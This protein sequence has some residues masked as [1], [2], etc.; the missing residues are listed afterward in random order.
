M[1]P[2]W[3]CCGIPTSS[4]NDFGRLVRRLNQWRKGEVI[5]EDSADEVDPR[6]C[7]SCGLMLEFVG[8][9]CPRCINRSAAM[10]RVLELLRPYWLRAS[11]MMAMLL[12]GIGL[13]MIGPRLTQF[14]VDHVLK[15]DGNAGPNPF[16]M[17]EGWNKLNLLM[18]VV[19]TLAAVQIGRALINVFNGRLGSR[20]GTSI[21]YDIRGRLVNHLEKLSLGYYDKQQVG[22]LVGRVAYDTEAVQ[23]FMGQLTGGFLMQLLLV[24][25]SAM[26]M[27]SLEPR[28]ALWTL[29]PAPLVLG[30]TYVFYKFVKPHYRRFWDRSSKQAGMLNGI[31]SGIRVVKAFAQEDRELS[32][33]QQSSGALRD[34]RYKVDTSASTFYPLMGIVFQIGGW[35][36][37]Y[38]GG[39]QVLGRELTLGTLLAF[40]GYL[41]MFYGPLNQL[42]HLT[43]WI[44]QFTTQ[45]HRIFEVLDTP[46]SIQDAKAPIPM[47]DVQ[48]RIVFDNVVF[49]Y[50]RQNPILKGVSFTIEPG[51][52]IGIVGR[53]GSGKTT[54]INLLSRFYDIDEGNITLDGVDIRQAAKADLQRQVGVV[55]QEP[56]LFRGTIWDNLTY[57][58]V[59]ATVEQGLSA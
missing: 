15:V 20:V 7:S 35:I 30:G 51:Q 1:M 5:L 55:L 19:A 53:S 8:E 29:L 52:M 10:R 18:L 37:W 42:T 32:R 17:L 28:L 31:L 47:P 54:I 9:S 50:S 58:R 4:S 59:D 34:A 23:G 3:M 57:G 46:V 40:F 33:F 22:S 11:M 45:M 41:H 14:L 13:D 43:S 56:F 39:G 48:G 2:G 25:F 38:V 26:M 24:F 12:L 6:R 16:P 49:G 36:V 21:T 27:F 44:T